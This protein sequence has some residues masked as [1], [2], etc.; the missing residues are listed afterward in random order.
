M[1]PSAR[2][3][4]NRALALLLG[5]NLLNY[6]DRYILAAVEL[7]VRNAFFPATDPDSRFKTGLLA[8]VFLLSYMVAAPFF[9]RLADRMSRWV[10]IGLAAGVWSLATGATGLAATF[11]ML[12]LTRAFVGIGEGG[13][14]PAAPTLIADYF[15]VERRGK[16]MAWFYLAIPV[17]S[18]IGFAFGGK[19]AEAYGWRMPFFLVTV[20][21]LLLA[22][23]CLRQRDPRE[24]LVP[25]AK[26]K[27]TLRRDLG[28]LLRIRAYASNTAA[29]TAMTFAIGG[30][31]FWVPSYLTEFRGLTDKGNV[32]LIFGA[33]TA[34]A[35]ALATLAGGWM[36]D[37]YRERIKGSY[38]VVSGLGMAVS[39]PC[40]LA[41]LWTPFPAA[42]V[43]MFLAVFFL[44]FNTGPSNTALANA[45]PAGIRGSGFA[46]NILLIHALGDAISPPLLGW[47]A[48]RT[49][50]NVAFYVVAG[51]MALASIIWLLG[52]RTLD[53]D[54]RRA[55][56]ASPTPAA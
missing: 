19:V 51:M 8:T 38:F 10:L 27:S 36:G 14:G 34:G 29:M 7:E 30:I 32:N 2:S 12:V 52:A 39:V 4:A 6:L 11:F 17:G 41:M 45:V 18:A 23:L 24:S 44:F 42:W 49:N 15:P 53:E 33:I 1:D 28:Q 35:G 37:R 55:E 16:M 50:Y 31:S 3:A 48:G 46:L 13:F 9:G 5:L 40:L 26:P 20:P 56:A 43:L 22:L 21:G 47:I 25:V 54:T